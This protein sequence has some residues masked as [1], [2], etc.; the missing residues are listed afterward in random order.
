MSSCLFNMTPFF[1][2]NDWAKA[3]ILT[4]VFFCEI[5]ECVLASGVLTAN[6]PHVVSR[7]LSHRILFSTGDSFGMC[8][9]AIAVAYATSTSALNISILNIFDV[10]AFPQMGW[11]ATRRVI[12]TMQDVQPQRIIASCKKVSNSMCTEYFS[13]IAESTVATL[14]TT[15]Q[16]LPAISLRSLT[17]RCI[18]SCLKSFSVFLRKGRERFNLSL[19]HLISYTGDLVRAVEV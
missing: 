11:I 14:K 1:P 3:R 2:V 19:S 5:K 12:A 15:P 8:P 17:G 18:N 6:L 10:S 4:G 7:E 13:S 16:P 9:T